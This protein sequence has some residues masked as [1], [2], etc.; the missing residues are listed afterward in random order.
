MTIADFLEKIQHESEYKGQIR[1][2]ETLPAREASY[3]ELSHP[4]RRSPL[5]A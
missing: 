3:G 1:H 4:A 2:V 5:P